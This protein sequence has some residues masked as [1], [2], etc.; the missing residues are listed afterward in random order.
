MKNLAVLAVIILS[1][2]ANSVLASTKNTLMPLIPRAGIQG[3]IEY[4]TSPVVDSE[5]TF[6]TVDPIK[7]IANKTF[8]EVETKSDKNITPSGEINA[9]NIVKTLPATTEVPKATVERTITYSDIDMKKIAVEVRD[10]LAEENEANLKNLRILWHATVEKSDTI[11]FAIM[12]LSNPDGDKDKKGVVKTILTPLT[13]VAPLIGMS[14]ASPVASGSA[15]LGS[16]VFSSLLADDSIMNKQL[17]RVTDTDLV[18]FAQKIDSLQQTLV[19]LY[20]DYVSAFEALN[21]TDKIVENRY[22]YYQA[23]QNSSK[24]SLT[25]ADVFYRESLDMQYKARQNVLTT[26]AALEQFVGNDALIEVDKK[27]KARLALK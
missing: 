6:S 9:A 21:F 7:P 27:I 1:I 10:D 25:L 12:K 23:A 13:S 14:S 16:G 5:K 2:E 24:E 26:R 22:K 3:Q 4:K 20:Y 19:N 8:T 17:S 15:V 11:R 18:N